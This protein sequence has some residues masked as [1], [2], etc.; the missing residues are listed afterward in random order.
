MTWIFGK[1]ESEAGFSE[2]EVRLSAAA[3]GQTR[4]ELHHE[5]VADPEM[6]G[7]FGP[8]AVGVGWDLALLGLALHLRGETVRDPAAWMA[9]AQARELVTASSRAWGAA[10]EASGASAAE[11]AE[12]AENTTT[13]Y[14][15][16]H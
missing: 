2:V 1:P 5:A 9:S 7:K 13:F 16:P 8:G 11:A 10:H 4:F 14:A 3:G 6:W 12:A 15:P